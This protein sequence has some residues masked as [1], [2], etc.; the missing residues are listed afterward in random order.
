MRCARTSGSVH[1]AISSAKM[2]GKTPLKADV[3][4]KRTTSMLF[5]RVVDEPLGVSTGG[6]PRSSDCRK[7]QRVEGA[8]L[9]W[10][11][12]LQR[13]AGVRFTVPGLDHDERHV[14]AHRQG[15]RRRHPD[16]A[17]V[18]TEPHGLGIS[19]EPGHKY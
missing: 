5:L 4:R 9:G 2:A 1:H 19:D 11:F 13:G 10:P 3:A 8:G 16:E 18:M 7:R 17:F 12:C 15:T 14:T 6:A